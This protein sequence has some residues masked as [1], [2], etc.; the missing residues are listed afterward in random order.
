MSNK[1]SAPNLLNF[2]E[3]EHPVLRQAITEPV[4]FPLSDADKAL[5][6]DMKYSIQKKQLKRVNAA[7]KSA[8]G[9]AANQWGVQKRIFLYCPEGDPLNHLEVIINPSYM[10]IG[11]GH[12]LTPAEDC[13]WES[14][15][16]VPLATGNIKRYTHIRAIY[17]NEEGQTL[18][19]DLSGYY[20][21]VW[22]HEN[23]HL[24]GF[25]YDDPR[26]NRCLEKHTF[27]SNEEVDNFYRS[28]Y[29]RP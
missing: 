19:K 12:G 1:K 21:R 20:A 25:L 4:Q 23:D 17:Q 15:F 18:T 26:T 11:E 2:V 8:A 13:E 14:C 16:S 9:M 6:R 5:I 22:Q 27:N 24:N 3:Y 28:L 10:P 7:W 29:H